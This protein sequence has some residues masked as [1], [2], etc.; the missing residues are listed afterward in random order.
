MKHHCKTKHRNVSRSQGLWLSEA[1]KATGPLLCVWVDAGYFQHKIK[2]D[3]DLSQKVVLNS[4]THCHIWIHN[5][6]HLY[7]F[8]C[9]FIFRT[10]LNPP[11]SHSDITFVDF[12]A[13]GQ[14]TNVLQSNHCEQKTKQRL[15]GIQLR[16]VTDKNLPVCQLS[17]LCFCKH[18]LEQYSGVM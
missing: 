13:R 3:K 14:C 16:S 15:S 11:S 5:N 6:F 7:Q 2:Q 10:G 12:E 17:H 18:L 8:T 4:E 1:G 9:C